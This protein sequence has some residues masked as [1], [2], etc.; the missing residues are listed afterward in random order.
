MKRYNIVNIVNEDVFRSE[1]VNDMPEQ[2]DAELTY[3]DGDYLLSVNDIAE[4]SIE[5]LFKANHIRFI[6][7][8]VTE[9]EYKGFNVTIAEDNQFY[10]INFN[11]GLGDGIY[12]KSD[13]TLDAALEDQANIYKE[14]RRIG[15]KN[16]THTL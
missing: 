11:T 13:W 7:M 14:K 9:R 16:T 4:E 1:V 6:R 10:Y 8:D 3:K 15:W 5:R 12:E 2:W